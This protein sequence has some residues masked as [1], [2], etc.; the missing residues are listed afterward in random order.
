LRLALQLLQV[1]S[2]LQHNGMFHGDVKPA[3][4]LLLPG[5][6]PG[7]LDKAVVAD[8]GDDVPLAQ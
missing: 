3:N 8:F 4:M 5:A 1:V 7:G 6:N 2:T